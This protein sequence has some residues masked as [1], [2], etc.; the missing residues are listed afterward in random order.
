MAMNRT[1][2]QEAAVEIVKAGLLNGT[3]KLNGNSGRGGENATGD[4]AYLTALLDGL[5]KALEPKQQ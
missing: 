4:V 5:V 1:Q 3:I 2:A